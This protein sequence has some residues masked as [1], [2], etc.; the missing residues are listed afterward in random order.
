[1]VWP[2]RAHGWT[3]D[4]CV[5]DGH[6]TSSL[7]GQFSKHHR[8]GE[9]LKRSRGRVGLTGKR[10]DDGEA[11]FTVAERDLGKNANS[12]SLVD[13]CGRLAVAS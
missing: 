11:C 12:S 1:L 3:K 5:P 2:R 13:D 8:H 9:K 7:I 6:G 4:S 10:A